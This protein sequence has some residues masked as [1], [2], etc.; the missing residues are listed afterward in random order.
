MLFF[1]DLSFPVNFALSLSPKSCSQCIIYL[2]VNSVQLW[3]VKT[4]TRQDLDDDHDIEM[5][6][7]LIT[8]FQFYKIQ[9]PI[10]VLPKSQRLAGIS[11]LIHQFLFFKI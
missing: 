8:W 11:Y 2:K 5:E 1:N 10:F 3:M 9:I 4:N 7:G 6:D